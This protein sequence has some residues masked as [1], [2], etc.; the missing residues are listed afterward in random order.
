MAVRGI[1][2][3]VALGLQ[4][5][6]AGAWGW[7]FDA[8]C[9]T[10]NPMGGTCEDGSVGPCC[11][12]HQ[13][14]SMCCGC[15]GG[16]RGPVD[17]ADVIPI[18]SP[19]RKVPLN[20]W[21]MLMAHDAA[22][23]Y[24]HGDTC[25]PHTPVNNWAVTQARGGWTRL[26]GCGARAFDL[27]PYLKKNGDLVMHHGSVVFD[28]AM[29]EAVEDVLNWAKEKE[30]TF[31]YIMTGHPATEGG[32]FHSC[33]KKTESVMSELGVKKL[34]CD[35][36]GG[37]SLGKAMD[38]GK[39]SSGGSV[40][41]SWNNCVE[42]YY[43]ESIVCYGQAKAALSA[44]KKLQGRRLEGEEV[45]L[46]LDEELRNDTAEG[47]ARRLGLS[48][49]GTCYGSHEDRENGFKPFWD[50]MDKKCNTASPPFENRAWLWMAQAH[51]Q[52]TTEAIAEGTARRGCILWDEQQSHMNRLVA[53]KIEAGA[54]KHLDRKSVV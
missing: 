37:M 45:D 22:T 2:L 9:S 20:Q 4:A 19:L 52:Y 31:V 12:V 3:L 16:C 41:W 43:D 24:A 48:G 34:D 17:E 18:T 15:E 38:L 6:L 7:L 30:D 40:L 49:A 11:G 14:N 50:Y 35:A 28:S 47:D 13:C 39:L 33:I 25:S 42:E 54:Y 8:C 23:A 32:D 1:F 5:D 21:P 10:G 26:L 27:R 44:A 51:W 46:A 36:I 53:E 29:K